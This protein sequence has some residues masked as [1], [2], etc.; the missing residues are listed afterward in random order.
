MSFDRELRPNASGHKSV[1]IRSGVLFRSKMAGR[2]DD[3]SQM[4]ARDSKCHSSNNGRYKWLQP[5][6]PPTEGAG[7]TESLTPSTSSTPALESLER[8][9]ERAARA[10]HQQTRRRY[11]SAYV[12]VLV[13]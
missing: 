13:L 2:G 3:R 1:F 6:G 7:E 5:S 10:Q 4:N 9:D 12:G 8:V 11:Q